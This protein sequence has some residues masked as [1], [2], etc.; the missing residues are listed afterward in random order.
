M[1]QQDID[2]GEAPEPTQGQEYAPPALEDIGTFA[3]L[4]QLAV[5]GPE[6]DIEGFS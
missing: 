3:E 6:A 4:T 1:E 5:S 2:R